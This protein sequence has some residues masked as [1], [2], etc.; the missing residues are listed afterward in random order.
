MRSLFVFPVAFAAI[1]GLAA[2]QTNQRGWRET[3]APEEQRATDSSQV[4]GGGTYI[5]K[6]GTKV[7]LALIN[8]VNSKHSA[9]GD[10]IYLESVFPILVDGKIVIPPGSYFAGTVTQVKR[11]GRVKGRGEIFLRFDSLIL[12]NGVTRDFRARVG[13]LDGRS[14]EELDRK[15]GKVTSQG[16][17][18]GDARTVGEATAAGAGIGAIA[19][20]GSSGAPAG[21]IGMGAG[22]A[23]GA[24]GGLAAVLLTRGPEAE[25]SRGT[26][27]DMVLDRDLSFTAAEINFVNGAPPVPLDGG[28]INSQ[29]DR[30]S[31]ALG[32]RIP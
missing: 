22:A 25:L 6:S 16:N 10:R 32:R 21:A 19:G 15:E 29:R 13:G 14:S 26:E 20:V 11:P 30:R 23:A 2:G 1:A 8:S 31:G 18:A 27:L 17:K 12:P 3:A 7:P 9:A 5:V 28:T 24:L 4:D